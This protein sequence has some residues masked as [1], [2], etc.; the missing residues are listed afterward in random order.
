MKVTLDGSKPATTRFVEAE[1]DL[2][3]LKAGDRCISTSSGKDFALLAIKSVEVR[4]YAE[5]DD[6]LALE[7]GFSSRVQLMDT[8]KGFYPS[9]KEDSEIRVFRFD[10]VH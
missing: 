5:I 2:A 1:P 4:S 10:V 8:L 6:Q 7:E 3:K 9:I